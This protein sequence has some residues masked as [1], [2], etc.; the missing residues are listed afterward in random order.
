[1][2]KTVKRIKARSKNSS[3]KG[4]RSR[5]SAGKSKGPASFTATALTHRH[6]RQLLIPLKW[7]PR[8]GWNKPHSSS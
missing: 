6:L 1:M 3:R 7:K 5:K 4:N 2:P 8:P